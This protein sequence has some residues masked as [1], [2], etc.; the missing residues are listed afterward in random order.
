MLNLDFDNTVLRYELLDET[1]VT[2][3]ILK[4]STEFAFKLIPTAQLFRYGTSYGTDT[5]RPFQVEVL[6]FLRENG[7]K[8]VHALVRSASQEIISMV[9]PI[10]DEVANEFVTLIEDNGGLFSDR[11]CDLGVEWSTFISG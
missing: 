7:I 6:A 1:T 2:E 8:E 10:G 11:A 5:N 9:L 4:S 3:E